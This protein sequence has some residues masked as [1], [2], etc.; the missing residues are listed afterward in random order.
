MCTIPDVT[1]SCGL[2]DFTVVYPLEERIARP[3][4]FERLNVVTGSVTNAAETPAKKSSH[5]G[6]IRRG[7][8]LV[9]KMGLATDQWRYLT[10]QLLIAIIVYQLGYR[11]A[12][13]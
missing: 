11:E 5:I 13:S 2:C 12:D 3:K 6:L 10:S 1:D 8:Q 9:L 4:A 7:D